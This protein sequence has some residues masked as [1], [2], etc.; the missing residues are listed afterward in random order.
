VNVND[1][2]AT[3]RYKTTVGVRSTVLIQ[4]ETG[5]LFASA[6]KYYAAYK[7]DTHLVTLYT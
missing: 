4:S 5:F 6:P 3:Y 1:V 7:P 2:S